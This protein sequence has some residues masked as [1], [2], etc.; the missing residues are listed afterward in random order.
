VIDVS[1]SFKSE[2]KVLSDFYSKP[3]IALY[4]PQYQRQ[5]SWD[6]AN[7]DQLIDD[8]VHGVAA[9][10]D[11]QTRDT[12]KIITF[13]GTVIIVNDKSDG[14][15]IP[16]FDQTAAPS[17]IYMI[18]DGQQRMTT[19]ALLA[20]ALFEELKH[21]TK[22]YIAEGDGDVHET[23]E[24]YLTMLRDMLSFDLGQ[25]QP[26]RKPK[27]IRAGPDRWTKNGKDSE[28]YR[29]TIAGFLASFIRAIPD[30]QPFPAPSGDEHLVQN[31]Q[32]IR[33][34]L[35][36]LVGEAKIR[37]RDLED[38]LQ[39]PAA[40]EITERIAPRDF[41]KHARPELRRRATEDAELGRIIQLQAFSHYLTAR[42]CLTVVEPSDESWAF[43]MFQSLNATGTPLT[44]L[45]TFKPQVVQQTTVDLK[46]YDETEIRAY[47][48]TIEELF[49]GRTAEAVAKKS[50]TNQLLTL[51]A[52]GHSG[53]KLAENFREQRSWLKQQYADQTTNPDE[54]T[55]FVRHIRD[56]A[57]FLSAYEDFD[58]DDRLFGPHARITY[59][60][61]QTVRLCLA[62][63][64]DAGQKLAR[65]ILS[66]LHAQLIDTPSPDS[67]RDFIEG[68]CAIAAFYTLWRSVATSSKLDSAYRE[69]MRTLSRE[70]HPQPISAV[71]VKL[72]LQRALMGKLNDPSQINW[73][74]LAPANLRYGNNENSILLRFVLLVTAHECSPDE[75]KPGLM[76]PTKEGYL[77]YLTYKHWKSR[78]LATIE[79]VAPVN[80]RSDG[81][82]EALFEG[83]FINQVGNLTLLPKNVN[84][85]AGN[86]GWP[87]KWF[88]YRHL[89]EHDP[90]QVKALAEQAA[91]AG[92]EL[93]PTTLDL[94]RNAQYMRHILPLVQVGIN[95]RWDRTLVERR[96]ERI[97]TILWD[98][99]WA[100][101]N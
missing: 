65:G 67:E 52:A 61:R 45:E 48:D 12:D 50:M 41:W 43:E 6:T 4:V 29:S 14:Q 81:W 18:I 89:A 87:E 28:H 58:S 25:G 11:P 51:V 20:C 44:A 64:K 22:P 98:R 80:A 10:V 38:L 19:L 47:F 86:R 78:D 60:Q 39:L 85:S 62:Y 17:K 75:Q 24:Q 76:T 53:R 30:E 96:T 59:A 92:I 57:R 95:G 77:E 9:L 40:A 93:K 7:V 70:Q 49:T 1:N 73:F 8:V 68:C 23:T 26:T 5:Y 79:H 35:T 100:W 36:E 94:L 32:H 21:R 82:D 91:A 2:S 101:L 34:R 56:T 31:Y 27:I 13:L 83:D 55:A 90:V 99:M 37:N 42:C 54:R 15:N 63:L 3:G 88:Y 69:V 16:N 97:C 72:E 46:G 74:Q 71:E 66:R 84:T 33:R